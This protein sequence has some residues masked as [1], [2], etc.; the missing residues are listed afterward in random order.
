MAGS[1]GLPRALVAVVVCSAALRDFHISS[2]TA[3]GGVD[4]HADLGGRESIGEAVFA[5]RAH[6]VPCSGQR[7]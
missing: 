3:V 6:A 1:A 2:G 4:D 5:G 7:G